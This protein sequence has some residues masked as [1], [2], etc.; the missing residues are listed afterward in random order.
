[1]R[2]D[3]YLENCLVSDITEVNSISVHSLSLVLTAPDSAKLLYA[4]VN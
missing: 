3:I 2:A 4:A 1:M